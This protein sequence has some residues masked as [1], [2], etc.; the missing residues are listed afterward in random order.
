[1][2]VTHLS[3]EH[4]RDALGIGTATPRLSWRVEDAE[5]GWVQDGAELEIVRGSGSATYQVDG[6]AQ[7]LVPWPAEPLGSRGRVEVRVRVD[8][9]DWS[10]P[11]VVEAGLLNPDDWTAQLV[12]P[13]PDAA[14]PL[15]HPVF[16]LR[17]EVELREQPV[18]A[19][20]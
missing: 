13:E 20:W 14:K 17:G 16:W 12:Q 11:L 9:A 4:R 8:G 15:P 2:R 6:D 7:V 19:R 3:A 5:D 18:S 10:D 1:M